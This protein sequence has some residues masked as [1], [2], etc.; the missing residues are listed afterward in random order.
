MPGRRAPS[1]VAHRT[2]A[3]PPASLD[4]DPGKP[5]RVA[6]VPATPGAAWMAHEIRTPLIVARAIVERVIAS[7]LR[8]DNRMLLE[9]SRAHLERLTE[10]VDRVLD[11]ACG[12]LVARR[13]PVDLTA[14]AR[15]AVA[16]AGAESGLERVRVSAPDRL[17]IVGDEARLEIAVTN[18][19]R[20]AL[21][22]S[23][24]GSPISVTLEL[25][26]SWASLR[27]EDEGPGVP[28]DERELIFAPLVRG[29]A[30][31]SDDAGRGLGLFM[32]RQV[33]E[34]LGGRIWV[35]SKGAGSSFRIAI[36]IPDKG[37][38]RFAS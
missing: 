33:V 15:S 30:A 17:Q 1:K 22:F 10:S 38:A 24:K 5:D 14:I 3:S 18:L 34:E 2:P 12:G 11:W 4:A 8:D 35:E 26:G 36:P 32:A 21:R 31:M 23:P 7:E 28:E 29:R 27:V 19:I 16:A 13:R 25:S 6:D 37:D 9:R 20:N